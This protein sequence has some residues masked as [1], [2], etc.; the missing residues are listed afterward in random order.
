[1]MDSDMNRKRDEVRMCCTKSTRN[2]RVI[3]GA[4]GLSK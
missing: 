2:F 3:V 4:G 1:M